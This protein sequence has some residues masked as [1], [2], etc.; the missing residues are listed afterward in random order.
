MNGGR[1]RM[2]KIEAI[3]K[4][5]ISTTE[6]ML[7]VFLEIGSVK[8][9]NVSTDCHHLINYSLRGDQALFYFLDAE[10]GTIW[11]AVESQ[12]EENIFFLL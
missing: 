8:Y 9:I 1:C 12:W 11:P 10:N 4:I 5:Q 2:D 3:Y 7:S 6:A